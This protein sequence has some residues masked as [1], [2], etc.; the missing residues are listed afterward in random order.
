MAFKVIWTETAANDFRAIVKY[1][2]LYNPE[3]ARRLAERILARIEA[4]ATLPFSCRSVPEKQ[5]PVVREA[6]L[7]PYRIIYTVDESREAIYIVRIWHAARG[8]PVLLSS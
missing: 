4:A 7:K 5:D 2:A 3:A 6:L 8:T 1:I